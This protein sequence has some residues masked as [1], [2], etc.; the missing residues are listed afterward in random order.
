MKPMTLEAFLEWE[1]RQDRKYEFEGFRPVAMTGGTAEHSQIQFNLLGLLFNLL[2]GHRCRGHG[3]ELK[4]Q[5]AGRIRYPMLSLS[6]LPF[7]LAPR[8]SSIPS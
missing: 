1:S 5:V 4:I 8:L 7:H 2:R 6:A 3:S